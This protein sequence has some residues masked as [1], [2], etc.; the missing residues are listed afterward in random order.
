MENTWPALESLFNKFAGLKAQ[1]FSTEFREILKVVFFDKTPLNCCFCL[2]HP[3]MVA[4]VFASSIVLEVTYLGILLDLKNNHSKFC[5]FWH[6]HAQFMKILQK[7][8]QNSL[9]L[10]R[11]GFRVCNCRKNHIAWFPYML[12]MNATTFYKYFV[13]RETR[14]FKLLFV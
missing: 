5:F 3:R 2:G 11:I 1:V 10:S 14:Y 12:Q 13:E 4:N 7:S 6:L 9:Y 8:P